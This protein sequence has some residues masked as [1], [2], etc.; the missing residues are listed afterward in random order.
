MTNEEQLKDVEYLLE[1]L[2]T[3]DYTNPFACKMSQRKVVKAYDKLF[4]MRKKLKG[5]IKNE[6]N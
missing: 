4:A 1:V 5:E 3:C 2:G 6:T